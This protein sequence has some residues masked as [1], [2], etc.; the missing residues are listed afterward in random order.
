MD[1]KP[2]ELGNLSKITQLVRGRSK[3]EIQVCVAPKFVL[4]T[5]QY[6]KVGQESNFYGLDM[7]NHTH[8]HEFYTANF[9]PK[10]FYFKGT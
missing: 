3:K 9:S 1:L 5:P 10:N 7:F 6:F 8:I 4:L 2:W